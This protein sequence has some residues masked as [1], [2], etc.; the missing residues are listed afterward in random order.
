MKFSIFAC[1]RSA[2][3]GACGGWASNA[4]ACLTPGSGC[5]GRTLNFKCACSVSRRTCSAS[6]GGSALN[7]KIS[8]CC[9]PLEYDCPPRNSAPSCDFKGLSP[10]PPLA[11]SASLGFFEASFDPAEI[12]SYRLALNYRRRSS[13]LL[14]YL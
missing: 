7:F 12:R 1:A 13:C 6:N 4:S 2:P 8:S 5:D 9:A 14:R 3:N 10:L 11:L